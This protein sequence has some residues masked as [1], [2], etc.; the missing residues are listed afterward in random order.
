[1]LTQRVALLDDFVDPALGVFLSFFA[2]PGDVGR[3]HLDLGK[4]QNRIIGLYVAAGRNVIDLIGDDEF[5]KLLGRGPVDELFSFGVVFAAL[6]HLVGRGAQHDPLDARVE[7]EVAQL[8]RVNI[9]A[10]LA[11]LPS[12][13]FLDGCVYGF[14]NRRTGER[15]VGCTKRGR[16]L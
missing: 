1:M 3:N 5:G 8:I 13:V 14:L 6:Q 11:G 12:D 7:Q 9:A 16:G 2:L 15:R 4:I 10:E